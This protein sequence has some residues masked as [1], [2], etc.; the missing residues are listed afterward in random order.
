MRKRI[1]SVK[2]VTRPSLVCKA[3]FDPATTSA[4]GSN[5]VTT[6][7]TK[8]SDTIHSV[9]DRLCAHTLFGAFTADIIKQN[10]LF[11]R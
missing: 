5:S 9:K 10:T 6:F 4:T 7:V 1:P 2:L 8:T 11:T 3:G